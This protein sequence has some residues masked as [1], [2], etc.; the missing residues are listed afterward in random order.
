MFYTD[1]DIFKNK[2]LLRGYDKNHKRVQKEIPYQPYL[3]VPSKIPTKFRNINGAFVEKMEF[4]SIYDAK[5]FIKRYKDVS[6]F[7]IY[8]MDRFVYP[9]ISDSYPGSVQYSVDTIRVMYLDIEVDSTD[10]F[11]D[12]EQA[13]RHITA[14]AARIG[15]KRT[16]F[17]LKPFDKTKMTFV[18]D[19]ENVTYI[20]CRS[21]EELLAKFIQFWIFSDVDVV[22]GWNIEFFDIPYIIRRIR[23]VLG[24]EEA[25]KLS[26]W[27]RLVERKIVVRG[28]DQI[29]FFPVGIAVLDYIQLYK[30]FTYSQRESYSLDFISKLELKSQKI[31]YSEY[32]S[33]QDLYE[34]NPQLYIEYNIYDIDLVYMFEDKLRFIEL[35]F[36]ISYDAKVNYTD[37]LGSVLLWDVLIMNYLMQQN[38]VVNPIKKKPSRDFE[39]GFVKDPQI[40]MHDWVVSFDLTSLYPHIIMQYN[41]SPETF[42]SKWPDFQQDYSIDSLI[43]SPVDFSIVQNTANVSVTANG[44]M[45]DKSKYGFL[46]ALMDLQFKLRKEYQVKM[47]DAKKLFNETKDPKAEKEIA[48]WHNAQLA[49]KIQLNSAYGALGNEWFRWYDPDHAEAITLSSQLS[50]RWIAKHVNEYMQKLMKTSKDYIIAIDTDSI[51]VNFGPLVRSLNPADPIGFLDKVAKQKIEPFMHKKYEELAKNT[52]AYA[53]RMY[54][55]REAIADK[56]IW[57]AKKNYIAHVWDN[58]GIRYTEPELKMMGI[59]AIRSSTPAVCREKI[60][61][62]LKLIMTADEETVR[63]YILEFKEQFMQ[64]SFEE[65]AFPRSVKKLSKYKGSSNIYILGTPVHAKASLIY[66]H[67][68]QKHKLTKKY[69]PVYDMD[70]V[71]WAYLKEPNPIHEEVIAAPGTFPPEFDLDK[72]IDR[73]KMFHNAF[74]NPI[75]SFLDIIGWEFEKKSTLESFFE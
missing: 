54:M 58:E 62:T 18:K 43:E 70:K 47:K 6:N 64:L 66:N 74:L 16:V 15:K 22:T 68:L 69:S 40:G 23:R 42:E 61:E 50:I 34:K 4:D 24:E 27:R 20:Q 55:K 67:L 21:E 32:G 17:G 72:Y 71:K 57:R 19:H 37:A 59:E 28:K 52:N 26:P 14:V 35:V 29:V 60:K 1:V 73:E 31:D 38:I 9:F 56:A 8:G 3:F 10:G 36:A 12:I 25:K 45:Y 48:R 75:N 63:K 11:A 2:I 53:N 7:M 46:P 39:G 51:Y 44:C 65:I 5:D 41:I 13:D 49:K 30:K 33:L